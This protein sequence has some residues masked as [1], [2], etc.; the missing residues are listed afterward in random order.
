[1]WFSSKIY[2][3]SI[4]I[5]K[6]LQY[7]SNSVHFWQTHINGILSFLF[8]NSYNY[9]FVCCLLLRSTFAFFFCQ[10]NKQFLPPWTCACKYI[11]LILGYSSQTEVALILVVGEIFL[12]TN[13][14]K[15]KFHRHNICHCNNTIMAVFLMPGLVMRQGLYIAT[16][17]MKNSSRKQQIRTDISTVVGASLCIHQMQQRIVFLYRI[18]QK[19]HIYFTLKLIKFFLVCEIKLVYIIIISFHQR[20]LQA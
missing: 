16:S 4:N 17:C 15:T 2:I 1:M 5:C 19:N 18:V 13:R 9:N 20:F 7:H 6:S 3:T 8:A 10:S 12:P 11:A 14:K